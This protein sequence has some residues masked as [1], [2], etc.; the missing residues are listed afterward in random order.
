MA[1]KGDELLVYP[2]LDYC[3]ECFRLLPLRFGVCKTCHDKK[4]EREDNGN[5]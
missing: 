2:Q 3:D 5:G 1:K 4:T